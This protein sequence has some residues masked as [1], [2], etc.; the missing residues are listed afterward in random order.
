MYLWDII[1]RSDIFYFMIFFHYSHDM[2]H[3]VFLY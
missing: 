1:F 2:E 3:F